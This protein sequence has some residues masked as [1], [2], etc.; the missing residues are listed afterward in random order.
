MTAIERARPAGLYASFSQAGGLLHSSGVVGRHDGKPITGVLAGPDDVARGEAAALAAVGA[1]LRAVEDEFGSLA[2]VSKVVTLT[3]YLQATAD[4]TQ[5]AAVM[6][7]ASAALQ[8]AFPDAPL[9]ARTTI[10]VASLP[11]GGVVE[12]SMVL[13]LASAG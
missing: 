1:I 10:G 8:R 7:A 2:A 5:H 9:P 11:G 13:A 6:N 3:G 12:V 4:F